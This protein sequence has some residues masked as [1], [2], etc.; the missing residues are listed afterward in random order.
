ME[1]QL[2]GIILGLAIYN[3]AILDVHFPLVVY[4]K[5]LG[6]RPSF[7]DLVEAQPTLGRGLKQ[8]L[9]FE[10]DVEATFCRFV[11]E[12]GCEEETY[13]ELTVGSV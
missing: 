7:S 13:P 12:Q 10:G 5:L 6:Q 8:L 2:V 9:E 4:K 11:T 3:G 1:F